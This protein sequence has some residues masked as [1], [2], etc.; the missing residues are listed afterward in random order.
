MTEALADDAVLVRRVIAR[1]LDDGSGAARVRRALAMV[2]TPRT[3][4]WIFIRRLTVRAAPTV[5][6]R[7]VEALLA[8]IARDA[9]DPALESLA[10]E[11]VPALI[12]A[13]ARA[14]ADGTDTG[15][16]W[17]TLVPPGLPAARLASLLASH[18]LDIPQAAAAL[19]EAG[20]LAPLLAVFGEA[21][22]RLVADAL[23][24]ATGLAAPAWPM[25]ETPCDNA[26]AALP[27]QLAASLPIWTRALEGVPP[28]AASRRLAAQILLVQHAALALRTPQGPLA[29]L[30]MRALAATPGTRPQ[31]AGAAAATPIPPPRA[32]PP[33]ATIAIAVASAG[34][35]TVASAASS[36]VAVPAVTFSAAAAEPT[37]EA[38]HVTVRTG[39]GG[40]FFLVNALR[41]LDPER[42]LAALDARTYWPVVLALSRLLGLPPDDPLD[43]VLD[44]LDPASVPKSLSAALHEDLAAV[45]AQ[46]PWPLPIAVPARVRLTR[47]HVDVHLEVDAPDM[48]V[49]LAGLDLDPGWV[50][51]LG[52][53]IAFHYDRLP[54]N[55]LPPA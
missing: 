9:A 41:R 2:A 27:P 22:V 15:W 49:R 47:T 29:T 35:N 11:D 43:A 10:F 28:G 44:A 32:Q 16:P 8:E 30:L 23:S 18:P 13:F 40:V 6:A 39:F 21:E 37:F 3:R 19:A 38:T 20:L 4:R 52:R 48:A 45:Y 25:P 34:S 33:D 50:P 51:W 36:A 55:R 53:V 12:V 14:A 17:L 42:R 26:P 54:Q 46:G 31:A 1:G 7:S 24:R 5:L